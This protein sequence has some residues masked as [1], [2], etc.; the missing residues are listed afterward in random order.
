MILSNEG[1]DDVTYVKCDISDAE[2]VEKLVDQVRYAGD[3]GSVIHTAAYAPVQTD[4]KRIFEVNAIGTINVLDAFYPLMFQGSTMTTITSIA[5]YMYTPEE[6][7]LR[8]FDHPRSEDFL[9][10]LIELADEESNLAYPISKCFCMHYTKRNT[11]RWAKKGAR[12]NTIS[13]GCFTTPMGLADMPGGEWVTD[14]TPLGRWGHPDE[15]AS[16][17]EFLI[18]DQASYITGT[19]ILV[20]G[21]FRA[22]SVYEQYGQIV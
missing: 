5:G 2:Q 18:S 22:N 8:I 12:V 6:E 11:L 7:A 10:K 16:A 4:A 20:D 1:I 17:I 13:A 9:D 3:V 15:I 21:G 14:T 19:D